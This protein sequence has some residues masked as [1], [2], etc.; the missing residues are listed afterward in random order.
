MSDDHYQFAAALTDVPDDAPLRVALD[1]KGVLLC[2]DGEQIF[3]V[4]DRCSHADQEL[5]GG[6]LRN[7]WI[8]CPAHF[9]R[10]DLETGE[11]ISGPATRPIMVYAVRVTNG[12]VEVR[13]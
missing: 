9:A 3:A 8:A 4:A 11:P 7:G 10:F 5:C 6:K 2:R 12:R 1:G 13:I